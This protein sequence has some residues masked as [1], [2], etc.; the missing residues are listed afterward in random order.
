[1]GLIDTSNMSKEEIARTAIFL[2]SYDNYLDSQIENHYGSELSM[3]LHNEAM[4]LADIPLNGWIENTDWSLP[5]NRMTQSEL[6]SLVVGKL[7]QLFNKSIQQTTPLFISLCETFDAS[8]NWQS[9]INALPSICVLLT[10]EHTTADCGWEYEE[11][12]K[13]HNLDVGQ[14][15]L[16]FG[17]FAH[18]IIRIQ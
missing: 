13:L 18:N 7:M 2:A 8:E 10:P 17:D 5:K 6:N 14:A 12:Q 16:N 3:D 11:V 15:L 9:A 4:N 1:M